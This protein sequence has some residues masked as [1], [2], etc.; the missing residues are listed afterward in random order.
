MLDELRAFPTDPFELLGDW[1]PSNDEPTRPLMTVATVNG[2][3][4]PD[5]RS[6]LL[7]EWDHRG[8]SF[9]TDSRSRKVAH[10]ATSPAVALCIPLLGIP[11]PGVS[12]QLTVQGIASPAPDDE[13]ARVYEAR[14]PY[15]KQLAWQNTPEFASLPQRDREIAWADFLAAHAEGFLPPTTWAGFIVR[16]TRMTFWFGSELT[17]SRRVEYAR[18]GLDGVWTAGILAG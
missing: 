8:F 18:A 16:P 12:H 7:S 17:A 10:L 1:L 2:D 9:H 11:T 3:G 13:L 6:L 4:V 15:L 14:R 5:A